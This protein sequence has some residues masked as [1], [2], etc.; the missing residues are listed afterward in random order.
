M[1]TIVDGANQDVATTHELKVKSLTG[2]ASAG[3]FTVV[4][5]TG[6]CNYSGLD[7]TNSKFTGISGCTGTKPED[8][9]IVTSAS[10]STVNLDQTIDGAHTTLN[11]ASGTSFGTGAGD[12]TGSGLKGTCH[13]T[14]VSGNQLTGVSG[15]TGTAKDT[16][17]LVIVVKAGVYKWDAA[18]KKW[19]VQT[20]PDHGTELPW[21]DGSH[22]GVHLFRLAEHEIISEA[23][24][25]AGKTDVGIAG[26]VAINIVT[27]DKTDALVEG[28]S[29]TLSSADITIKAQ[30]NELDL[31]KA[32]SEAEDAKSAGVGAAVAL[33]VLTSTETK[34]VVSDGV[35]I[36]GGRNV[37]IEALSRRQTETEVNM[38]ASG[39]DTSVAPGVALVVLDGE[40]TVAKLGTS[41]T[42]LTVTGTVT[43]K[44]SHDGDFSAE[45]KSVAAGS[46]AVGVSIA[47]NIVLNWNTLAEVD[48]DVSGTKVEIGADSSTNTEAHADA[49]TKGADK[50][51]NGGSGGK[52]SSDERAQG[53]ITDNPNTSGNSNTSSLP[54]AGDSNTG[55]GKG[56][57]ET[58][59]QGGDSNSGGVG[60]AASV[61]LNWVVTTNKAKIGN[62]AHV[63]A[64]DDEL[65]LSAGNSTQAAAKAT[66][67]SA[68]SDGSHI[69]AAVGVNVADITNN[70]TVGQ[71]AV[72]EGHG[73]TIEAVNAGDKK[74]QLIVW[75]LAGAGGSS[76]DNG[77]ASVAASIGVEVVFFHTEASVAKGAHL[78]SHGDVDVKAQNAIGIQNM[79]LSGAASAGGAGVGGAIVVNVFPNITTTAFIDSDTFSHVT[80]VDATGTI[81][82]SAKSAITEADPIVVPFIGSLPAFSSVALA[83]AA[84]SGGAAVSGSVIVDVFFITTEARINSG[85]ELNQHQSRLSPDHPGAGR[86]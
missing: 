65:T 4:G 28:G 16:T 54:K 69:A 73:I 24:A 83:G 6:T 74:N 31:A 42:G 46:T 51:D 27:N 5:L 72:L 39:D 70:A 86:R 14:G 77:G 62:N 76:E 34:A 71:D 81:D 21:T 56:N 1:Q 10:G 59:A 30:A 53:E 40:D 8:K 63:T 22:A 38:G 57:S 85:T 19:L 64:T 43:V 79:A 15:C 26:A 36:T 23:N 11:V 9:A 68:S 80:Q 60:V 33:N 84:S 37:D 58:G 3:S 50:N 29:A 66:G 2:F 7:T 41:S 20:A 18:T 78:I 44:A 35:A 52:K 13:Y 32:D 67:L 17:A 49:T 61:S 47:L 48:R 12:F 25:G 45:A 75:G 55:T 82:V